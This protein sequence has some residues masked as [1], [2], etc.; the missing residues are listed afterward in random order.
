MDVSHGINQKSLQQAWF[1]CTKESAAARH[2]RSY[3]VRRYTSY[4]YAKGKVS[5]LKTILAG[6]FSDLNDVLGEEGVTQADL[7]NAITFAIAMYG[8][9]RGTSIESAHFVLQVFRQDGCCN[10]YMHTNTED[11]RA[12]DESAEMVDV[13]DEN[14]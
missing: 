5:A 2:A 1:K 3:R 12:G 4:P 11:G 8:L 13:N 9:P 6:D 7:M 10:Q 14:L